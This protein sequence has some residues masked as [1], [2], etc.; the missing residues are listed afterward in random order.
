MSCNRRQLRK[1]VLPRSFYDRDT[2]EVTRDLLG[3]CLVRVNADGITTGLIV[4]AEAYLSHDDPACHASRGRSRRNATMFGPCGRAYVYSIHA[5]YCLNAVTEPDG[6]P[7]AVLI[8][9][10]E[11][12]EGI[13]LMRQRRGRDELRD[14]TRG[15]ARLCE[16]F[17]IDREL[18][19]WDLSRGRELWI[20]ELPDQSLSANEI[21]T[22][23]RVGISSAQD[24]PL[25]FFVTSSRYVSKPGRPTKRR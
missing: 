20:A 17:A 6:I 18:D 21:T 3:K 12:L 25:R 5:R 16:A 8:R 11:P 4:E 23:T 15:P 9:A 24:L 14:L 19:G 2:I 22:A 13:E 10:V 1:H 7:S